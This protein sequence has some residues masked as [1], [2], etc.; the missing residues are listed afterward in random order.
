MLFLGAFFT[1]T[2]YATGAQIVIS[3]AIQTTLVEHYGQWSFILY[4]NDSAISSID[5]VIHHAAMLLTDS[6]IFGK[7]TSLLTARDG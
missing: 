7:I 5:N 1:S 6:K 2:N 4:L 3:L